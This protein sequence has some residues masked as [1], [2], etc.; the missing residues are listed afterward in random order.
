MQAEGL[1]V[2]L[3]RGKRLHQSGFS[4]LEAWRTQGERYTLWS[5]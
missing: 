3:V 1:P 5:S 4:W 2:F